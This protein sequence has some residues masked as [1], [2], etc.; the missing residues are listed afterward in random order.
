MLRS[1]VKKFSPTK[2][3]V[4]LFGEL[5]VRCFLE[6]LSLRESIDLYRDMGYESSSHISMASCLELQN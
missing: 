5:N 1:C 3:K 6:H 2:S 4:L